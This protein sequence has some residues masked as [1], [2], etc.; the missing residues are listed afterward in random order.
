MKNSTIWVLITIVVLAGAGVGAMAYYRNDNNINVVP[1]PTPTLTPTATPTPTSE[2]VVKSG[3]KGT[4][5]LGPTCPVMRDPP[6]TQCADK[7]YKT[8]LAVTTVSG[9]KI[10]KAFSSDANGNFEV[11]AEPGNYEIRSASG[12]NIF[13]HCS[14]NGAIVVKAGSYTTTT[15]YCDTGIR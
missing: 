1:T 12:A 11:E 4:V 13:P 6:D 9:T 8:N 5:L 7:R 15:I 2:T 3:I 10:I 14:T